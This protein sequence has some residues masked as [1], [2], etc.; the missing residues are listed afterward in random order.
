MSAEF[1]LDLLTASKPRK[2]IKPRRKEAERKLT[3]RKNNARAGPKTNSGLFVRPV[4]G[5]FGWIR[6]S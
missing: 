2:D 6:G 5:T 1:Q 4:V 3:G